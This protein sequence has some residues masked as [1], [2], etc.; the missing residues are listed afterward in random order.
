MYYNV[1]RWYCL[2]KL[3]VGIV[4]CDYLGTLANYADMMP[5]RKEI[6]KEDIKHFKDKLFMIKTIEDLDLIY[7]SLNTLENRLNILTEVL[8]WIVDEHSWIVPGPQFIAREVYFYDKKTKQLSEPQMENLLDTY[9]PR[10]KISNLISLAFELLETYEVK[11]VTHI[12]DGKDYCYTVLGSLDK[13]GIMTHVI[14]L[15]ANS[16]RDVTYSFL[17]ENIAKREKNKDEPKSK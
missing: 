16:S 8:S 10:C 12:E 7:F 6:F 13:L 3:K 1:I 5:K 17:R 9:Q 11:S 14:N 15:P 4:S 2:K